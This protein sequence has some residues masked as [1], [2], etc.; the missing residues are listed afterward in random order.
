MDVGAVTI[1]PSGAEGRDVH[2]PVVV[3]AKGAF[4]SGDRLVADFAGRAE[5]QIGDLSSPAAIAASTKGAAG[6]VITLQRMHRE[7]ISAL[8]E[9]VRVI[10]R[11]GVGLDSVD[12]AAAEAAG[13]TVIHEPAYG[14]TEV[15][16]HALALLL[17]L[18]R[19]VRECDAF[20][21]AGWSGA[22]ALGAMQPLDELEVGLV[23]CGRIGSA[24]A[25]MVRPLVRTVRA[26]DP[27]LQQLPDGVE[28]ART[29]EELLGSSDIVSLHAPLTE[30]TRSLIDTDRIGLMRQDALLVNVSRGPMVD[31]VA[32]GMALENG[33]IAGAAL[34]VFQNEPLS[35]DSPLLRAPNAVLSPHVAAYS[36]RAT[37]RL[38]SWTTEDAVAWIEG[39]EI[40][41]GNLVVRGAR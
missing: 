16:S 24:F 30:H 10:G 14:A 34:D 36:V 25:A 31:E 37:W 17:T 7:E 33:Q 9:T 23:G 3:V 6:V 5:V 32:L 8:D 41:Y 20:V 35:P 1:E 19:K 39:K 38:A 22:M 29:L 21:R 27:L 11:A 26:Y 40:P 13:I 28:R 15:A 12:L 18:Q 4:S 2:L